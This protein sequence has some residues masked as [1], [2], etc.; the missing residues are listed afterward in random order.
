MSNFLLP[1]HHDFLG[2]SC[3]LIVCSCTSWNSLF[4]WDK[5]KRKPVVSTGNWGH[6]VGSLCCW[7]D[8][9]VILG[10]KKGPKTKYQFKCG[11]I[12]FFIE[13]TKSMSNKLLDARFGSLLFDH[14]YVF[15]PSLVLKAIH[16]LLWDAHVC[17]GHDFV[18]G[19]ACWRKGWDPKDNVLKSPPVEKHF[20][21]HLVLTLL[22]RVLGEFWPHLLI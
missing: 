17:Q 13:K 4:L 5:W 12:F 10:A 15:T 7:V 9:C 3:R 2:R 19:P 1:W 22:W 14:I 8:C 20:I 6:C 16:S 18:C 21:H 11:L